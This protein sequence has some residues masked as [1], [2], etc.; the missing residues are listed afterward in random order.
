MNK[1]FTSEDVLCRIQPT[2]NPN[3]WKFIVNHPV[4]TEGKI[5]YTNQDEAEN[6][7]LAQE[8]LKL[9]GVRQLHFF[10]NV[11]T[12]THE[13]DVSLDDLRD[14]VLAIIRTRLPVHN[15]D[16]AP[17]G[18]K[19]RSLEGLSKEIQLVDSILDRTVRHHLQ[20]DG[21]DIEVIDVQGN[22]V[23]IHFEGACGGC[24]SS[25]TGTL[26]AIEGILQDEFNPEAEVVPV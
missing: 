12:V 2:P 10:T 3:A 7:R 16:I 15:P 9:D 1:T 18:K 6:N 11:I 13:F 5:T 17:A 14:S 22:Q 23:L 24:P 20:A 25:T 26:M 19:K 21:G 8:L 4:L